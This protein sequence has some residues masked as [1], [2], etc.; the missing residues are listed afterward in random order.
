MASF[1]PKAVADLSDK[2][3][4]GTTNANSTIQGASLPFLDPAL[5]T[6]GGAAK[7]FQEFLFGVE[8]QGNEG[9]DVN[10][11]RA[12]L[13]NQEPAR[14]NLFDVMIILPEAI[15]QSS[16]DGSG[17][18]RNDTPR[19]LS[20][21][22][23][24]AEIPAKIVQTTEYRDY[25]PMFQIANGVVYPDFS[26]EFIV[27]QG[28]PERIVFERWLNLITDSD[29]ITESDDKYIPANDVAYLDDYTSK[30]FLIRAYDMDGYIRNEYELF[31]CFPKMIQST[32][33]SWAQNDEYMKMRVDFTFRTMRS[34]KKDPTQNNNG[35]IGELEDLAHGVIDR[36][37]N[38]KNRVLNPIE[39]VIRTGKNV[40]EAGRRVSSSA[41]G[42]VF[43]AKQ[44]LSRIR[45]GI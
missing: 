40:K 10:S 19:M 27:T 37:G 13:G 16:P 24:A 41:R 35:L 29:A 18:A 36:A 12:S 4:K 23:E 39:S 42:T 14:V 2:V 9:F 32:P 33:L 21:R 5:D 28:M 6:L 45:G 8:N 38:L 1:I 7:Q 43:S 3:A 20:Y 17:A 26:L 34:I 22:C 31:D 11:F 25:G 44:R 15:E 30:K